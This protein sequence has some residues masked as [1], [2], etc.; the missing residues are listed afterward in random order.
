MVV[1][2]ASFYKGLGR[3]M[4]WKC[5]DQSQLFAL[6][7]DFSIIEVSAIMAGHSPRNYTFDHEYGDFCLRNAS[8]EET[9][10]FDVVRGAIERSIMNGLLPATVIGKPERPWAYQHEKDWQL[11]AEIDPSKTFIQR[12]DLIN[13]LKD[14]GCYPD[15]FFPANKVM[16]FMDSNHPHYSPKL[17]A[18]VAA[19]EAASKTKM[20]DPSE[21]KNIEGKTVKTWAT[22]WLQI[23]AQ[24]YHV[25]NDTATTT[26]FSEMAGIMNWNTTGGRAAKVVEVENTSPTNSTTKNK[27]IK[28]TTVICAL[29]TDPLIY[30]QTD[31][32]SEL[33]F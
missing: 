4:K 11:I 18:T 7:D 3:E 21:T 12:E 9:S 17:A 24:K 23:H 26:A 32:D 14:R 10:T 13:W 33:P 27:T 8:L 30:I 15:F 16:D 28:K 25:S 22:H 2:L 5:L 6:M 31:T 19:W 20:E 29:K 1:C